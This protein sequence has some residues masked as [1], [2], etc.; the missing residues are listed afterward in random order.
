MI[1]DALFSPPDMPLW[2]PRLV[3]SV[4]LVCLAAAMANFRPGRV[5]RCVACGE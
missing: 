2:L 1:R 5:I 4:T 3:F